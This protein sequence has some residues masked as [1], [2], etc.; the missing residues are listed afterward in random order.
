MHLKVVSVK[1]QWLSNEHPSIQAMNRWYGCTRTLLGKRE[2]TQH[3]PGILLIRHGQTFQNIS[4]NKLPNEKVQLTPQGKIQTFNSGLLLNQLG[5]EFPAIVYTSQLARTKESLV[6]IAQ[7]W[8]VQHDFIV[9][10]SCDLNEIDWGLDDKA[11]I[12]DELRNEL[13]N[14]AFGQSVT[15]LR[16]MQNKFFRRKIL[17]QSYGDHTA[18]VRR[19]FDMLYRNHPEERVLVVAHSVTIMSILYSIYG[20][21]WE[22][23]VPFDKA[24][25]IPNA[26]IVS[27]SKLNNG[28]QL[29]GWSLEI[30]DPTFF[31]QENPFRPLRLSDLKNR[32]G[33]MKYT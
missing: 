32:Y 12:S 8:G 14:S 13:I 7:G 2:S 19:F 1:N 30:K 29:N 25:D 4:E 27:L 33:E 11:A 21:T 16:N 20:N 23:Y 22:Q 5:V 26:G 18:Q 6:Y 24:V 28:W 31:E 15:N 17:G 10:E 3:I 9:R